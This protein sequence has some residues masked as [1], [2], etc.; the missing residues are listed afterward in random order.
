MKSMILKTHLLFIF[1]LVSFAT[2]AQE[3][4]KVTINGKEF[5]EYE[6]QKS[7]GFYSVSKKFGVSADE[8]VQYNAS[9]KD[10]LKAGQIIFIP[11]AKKINPEQT[12]LEHTVE[13]KETVF[14]ISRL[15]NV[16][17]DTIYKHNPESKETLKKGTVLKIPTTHPTVVQKKEITSI[18]SQKTNGVIYH[19]V[20]EGETLYSIS[21]QYNIAVDELQSQNP[22]LKT[23]ALSKGEVLKI[24]SGRNK[25]DLSVVDSLKKTQTQPILTTDTLSIK[26]QQP[27]LLKNHIKVAF[28]LPFMLDAEKPDP[29][30]EKFIDFYQGA[31]LAID[32][33][34]K[35]GVSFDVLVFDTDRTEAKMN[36]ILMQN[37]LK[38]VDIIIGPAYTIHVKTVADFAKK[39]KIRL[40][41]PFSS[42]TEETFTNPYL[43]QCNTHQQVLEEQVVK[44]FVRLFSKKN[45]VVLKF[46]DGSQETLRS[47]INQLD[48]ELLEKNIYYTSLF[49]ETEKL[50]EIASFLKDSSNMLVL[51]T[52]NPATLAKVMPELKSIEKQ[53]SLFGFPDWLD[54]S[55]TQDDIFNYPTY[56][57]S[58]FYINYHSPE[59]HSFYKKF[60]ENFG[61]ETSKSIPHYNMLGYD[62]TFF[63]LKGLVQYNEGFEYNIGKVEA[64]TLQ[65]KFNFEKINPVGGY[66]NKSIFILKYDNHKEELI[67]E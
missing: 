21:H 61:N 18:S 62:M 3:Y 26:K 60:A 55:T 49:Y 40:V 19:T 66:M 44:S 1:L 37:Q 59:I 7:E 5:Y 8:I 63:F 16:P 45:I 17:I 33:L 12:F 31:L 23:H 48:K 22:G 4:K 29:A 50:D 27:V 30:A 2:F 36:D 54:L 46:K 39:H 41:V 43:F 28:L 51:M 56:L 6:V 24:S 34:K 10:G 47:Y 20:Q 42:K 9:A 15:Y 58:S 13:K 53:F 64:H 14:S 25:K 52:T 11:I 35:E 67:L 65:T 57:Y 38:N 32:S